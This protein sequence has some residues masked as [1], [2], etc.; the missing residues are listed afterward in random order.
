MDET[1]PSPFK[2]PPRRPPRPGHLPVPVLAAWTGLPWAPGVV[3]GILFAALF[4]WLVE[5]RADYHPPRLLGEAGGPAK[6]A[7]FASVDPPPG[8]TTSGPGSPVPIPGRWPEFRGPARD[9]ISREFIPLARSWPAGGPPALWSLTLG[10]GHAG[11][12]VH[13]GVVYLIDYDEEAKQD[14]IRALSLADGREIWRH[15][16]SVAIRRNHGISR[17]VPAVDAKHVVT[18]GPLCHLTCLD[19]ATGARLWAIDLVKAYGSKVPPW[20]AGQCPLLEKGVVYVAPAGTEEAPNGGVLVMAIRAE[21]GEVL[22]TAPSPGDWKMSHSTLVPIS[23]AGKRI[24]LYASVGGV[25]GVDMDTGVVLFTTTEFKWHTIAPSPV[26]LGDGRVVFTA[27]YGCEAAL[28]DLVETDGRIEPVVV[29]RTKARIFGAEQHTPIWYDH[30]LYAVLPKPRQELICTDRD[31]NE[32]WRSGSEHK[33]ELGPYVIGDGLIFAMN[34]EGLLS[35]IEATP[36]GFRL[37]S[38]AKVL[39]GPDSWGPMALV[40]G[41]LLLRDEF[42]MKC[43]DVRAA[44]GK[45][46]P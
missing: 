2:H 8:M 30:H 28:V 13:D 10:D 31:L 33:F 6:Q 5:T 34:D 32:I 43:L 22:W 4:L 25:A 38:Q 26:H 40:G 19:R 20:Y 37:L 14:A 46:Q 1:G 42:V 23:F 12:A 7:A 17:T 18:L 44:A 27:G 39:A 35:L 15:A 21:D 36:E 41:R 11:A 3:F 16:Y 9:N 24:L 29:K 45:E